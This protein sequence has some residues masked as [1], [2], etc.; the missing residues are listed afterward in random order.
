VKGTLI[1]VP[2]STLKTRFKNNEINAKQLLGDLKL[3]IEEHKN[4]MKTLKLRDLL[5]EFFI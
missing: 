3:S 2:Y 4:E 5:L 1:L